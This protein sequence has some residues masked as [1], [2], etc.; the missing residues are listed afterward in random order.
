M[1]FFQWKDT[2]T[3]VIADVLA[4]TTDPLSALGRS[5]DARRNG[6][7]KLHMLKDMLIAMN[8]SDKN[9][10]CGLIKFY[11]K[12]LLDVQYDGSEYKNRLYICYLSDTAVTPPVLTL[13]ESYLYHEN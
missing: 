6:G 12:K 5:S 9:V 10:R 7:G 4:Y 8:T 2:T 3:P 11:K 13:N 1:I